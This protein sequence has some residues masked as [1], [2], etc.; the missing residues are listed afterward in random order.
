L[1]AYFFDSSALVKLY[2]FE[3]GTTVVDAL[4]TGAGNRINISR[5]A[6]AELIS[7]F[8]IKVRTQ[9]ISRDDADIFSQQFRSDIADARLEVFRIGRTRLCN[10]GIAGPALCVP[11]APARA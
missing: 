7:A 6:H 11:N 4:V 10:R 1:P 2:H 5:L 9:V 3:A 8:A